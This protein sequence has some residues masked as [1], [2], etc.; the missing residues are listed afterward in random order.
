MFQKITKLNTEFHRDDRFYVREALLG[1]DPLLAS[2]F[3]FLPFCLKA[4]FLCYLD[5]VLKFR[6][7]HKNINAAY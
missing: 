4:I 3:F 7:T 5:H 6:L 2:F 1:M